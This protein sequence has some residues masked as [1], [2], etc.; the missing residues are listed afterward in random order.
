MAVLNK[1]VFKTKVKALVGFSLVKTKQQG[2]SY[3]LHPVVQN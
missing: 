1:L 2:G 3:T